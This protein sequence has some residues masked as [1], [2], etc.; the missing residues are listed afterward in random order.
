M[1][2]KIGD[3]L[4]WVG[5]PLSWRCTECGVNHRLVDEYPARSEKT[6]CH[7]GQR[8]AHGKIKR[9]GPVIMYAKRY[10]EVF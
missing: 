8:V 9:D 1:P 3:G 6:F 7:C 10:Y 2:L 5:E 4:S